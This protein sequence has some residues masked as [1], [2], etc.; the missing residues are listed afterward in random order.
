M[1]RSGGL[2]AAM[3][4]TV[5]V[6][7]LGAGTDEDAYGNPLPGTDSRADITGCSLQPLQGTDSVESLG[8]NYDQVVTRWRL[9]LPPGAD[10]NSADRVQ[11]GADVFSGVPDNESA[12]LDFEVD[13][14]PAPWPGVD[15]LPHHV[16]A[17]LK[18]WGG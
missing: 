16:E 5:T 17:M 11:Q 18:K 1:P 4:Q 8:A 6:V 10:I 2:P 15:G 14:D 12:V 3:C 13:G 7:R 9:F